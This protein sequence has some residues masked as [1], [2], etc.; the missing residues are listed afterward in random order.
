MTIKWLDSAI[1]HLEGIA[2]Y[3]AEHDPQVA[4]RV[5]RTIRDAVQHLTAYP[6][7]GRAGRVEGT[8]ELVVTG[9]PY[10]IAY[11]VRARRLEILC[12]LHAARR[13]PDRL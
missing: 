11:R 1:D 12:V 6:E 9:T 4:R 7:M 8:R 10:V 13:W 2:E 5:I 3:I